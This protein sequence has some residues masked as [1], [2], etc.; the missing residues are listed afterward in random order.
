MSIIEQYD[1]VALAGIDNLRL[2]ASGALDE[3]GLSGKL[4][5]AMTALKAFGE[6]T[7]RMAAENNR[8]S[9]AL[10]V[11]LAI[12]ANKMQLQP[13]WEKL[14]TASGEASP[15]SVRPFAPAKSTVSGKKPVK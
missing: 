2:V 6:S 13:L 1:S 7:R 5:P 12:G 3:K 4:K 8:L 15:K 14:A 11:G 9:V 10:K